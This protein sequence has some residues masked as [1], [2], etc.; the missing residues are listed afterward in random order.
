MTDKT[1]FSNKKFMKGLS[2][3]LLAGALYLVYDL[4]SI[5]NT[6]FYWGLAN[7]LT[8]GII[9]FYLLNHYVILPY[10]VPYFT[11]ISRKTEIAIF[12]TIMIIMAVAVFLATMPSSNL[13]EQSIYQHY[14]YQNV[15]ADYSEKA[16]EKAKDDPGEFL[17]FAVPINY[18]NVDR[19]LN[20]FFVSDEFASNLISEY[21]ENR[22]FL[23]LARYQ[24][25]EIYLNYER[26]YQFTNNETIRAKYNYSEDLSPEELYFEEIQ[27]TL[28]HEIGHHLDYWGLLFGKQRV[29]GF[30]DDVILDQKTKQKYLDLYQEHKDEL[31]TLGN[32]VNFERFV[33]ETSGR[34][35][36][37]EDFDDEV[38]VRVN[39][40]CLRLDPEKNYNAVKVQ[41]NAY[42]NNFQFPARYLE[43]YDHVIQQ[44]TLNY[45]KTF[46]LE[47][48]E[49][50]GKDYLLEVTR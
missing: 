38:V 41:D 30:G 42:C 3:Y 22:S 8:I 4:F 25:N 45:V 48:N 13:D 5:I 18:R 28:I 40:V 1:I 14:N 16:M 10:I 44:I 15:I 34:A 36:Q 46:V 9:G 37:Q 33:F 43:A 20:I 26:I 24:T 2:Y 29:Y 7:I 21:G 19:E 12:H 27:T 11:K 49:P 39:S 47:E 31:G 50:L 17:G 23:G 32:D 35:Y 6:S